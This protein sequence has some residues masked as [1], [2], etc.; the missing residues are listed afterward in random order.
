VRAINAVSF[1]QITAIIGSGL[2]ASAIA[3]LVGGVDKTLW[4]TQTINV[5]TIAVALPVSQMADYWG[6]KWILV[7]LTLL[8]CIGAILVSRAQSVGTVIAGFTLVGMNVGAQPILYAVASEILPRRQRG[9]ALT[10]L[11]MSVSIGGVIA[12]VMGGALLDGGKVENY[13]IY[14]YI[15]IG[16]YAVAFLGCLLFYNPPPRELQVSLTFS[17]KLQKLDWVGY[18]LFAPGLTLFS[19]A[20]SWSQNPYSWSDVHILATFVI[21]VVMVIAFGVYEW[22]FKMDGKFFL[23]LIRGP[24]LA[25]PD[26]TGRRYHAPRSLPKQEFC[27]SPR[28]C[29]GG[30]VVLLHSQHLFCDAVQHLHG[31]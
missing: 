25:T 5:L 12:L 3:Q 8:G 15:V 29:V 17:E 30:R 22:R 26:L 27:H 28:C 13:R 31:S 19:V 20:L 18:A 1:A 24:T 6:R 21:G 7:V 4:F 23:L 2:L 9:W 11:N 14:F 10:T 16:F